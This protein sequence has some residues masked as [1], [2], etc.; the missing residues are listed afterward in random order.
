[1][2]GRKRTKAYNTAA[3]NFI[4]V[5]GTL[6]DRKLPEGYQYDIDIIFQGENHIDVSRAFQVSADDPRFWT[7]SHPYWGEI[8]VQP[9]SIEED[10]SILNI[11]LFRVRVW[12]TVA[13]IYPVQKQL[14]N[15]R[16]TE[17]RDAVNDAAAESFAAQ[18]PV[19]NTALKNTMVSATVIIDN[20]ASKSIQESL[21]FAEFKK[22]VATAKRTINDSTQA[23]IDTFRAVI[24][25]INY[26][27]EVVESVNDRI[28]ILTELSEK[29]SAILLPDS[30]K[31]NLILYESLVSGI[32]ACV[33]IAGMTPGESDYQIRS[34][35]V[36]AVDNLRS[37]YETY[38]QNLD[39]T[40]AVRSDLTDSFTPADEVNRQLDSAVMEGTC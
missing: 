10:K 22:K 31:D 12:E 25:L 30:N 38:L 33:A 39:E 35:V 15:D 11:T 14:S 18:I 26:P 37:E 24:D 19:I 23:S 21:S 28:N 1:M 13:S 16:V 8:N 32:V 4:G 2:E 3:Y 29:L 5:A 17:L 7:I 9:V 34:E 20:T 40:Q 36:E 6:V 27:V